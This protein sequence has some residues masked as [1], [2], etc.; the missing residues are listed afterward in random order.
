MSIPF[1]LSLSKYVN[2]AGTDVGFASLLAV[3]MLALLY[4]AGAR[5]TRTLRDQ[6]EEAHNR[7]TSLEARVAQ[8]LRGQAARAPQPTQTGQIPSVAGRPG[9]V[10]PPSVAQP[11]GTGVARIRRP[12]TGGAATVTAPVTA[13]AAA[14][15]GA[16]AGAG[17]P[18]LGSATK[19][20]PSPP[21]PIV[22]A[23]L[24]TSPMTAAAQSV[25]EAY[26]EYD[27]DEEFVEEYGPEDTLFVP[28]GSGTDAVANG[29]GFGAGAAVAAPPRIQFGDDD[30]GG[31]PPRRTISTVEGDSSRP[32]RVA[33]RLVG[34][35]A[36]VVLVA[37]VVVAL[38]VIT[39]GSSHTPKRSAQV[40]TTTTTRRPTT[41]PFNP[42]S[43]KVSVL[44][45]TGLTGVAGAIGTDLTTAGYTVPAPSVT[46]AAVET[47]T[48]TVVGY[49]SG[50]K[51]AALKVAQ[52]LTNKTGVPVTSV[53]PATQAAITSCATPDTGTGTGKCPASVI[54]TVGTDL[55]SAANGG[56][57]A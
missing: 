34:A 7:I 30:A 32:R 47:V 43:I 10:P 26:P 42:K 3:A 36:A 29:A 13:G 8:A 53:A 15:L 51:T 41:V 48:T 35:I 25:P 11:V 54:V 24:S 52:A 44:N 22:A 49:R 12:T 2:S 4:F 39:G 9:V 45:G 57:G 40:R 38:L 37:I 56:S 20:I 46:N 23:P 5:E 16:P 50:Y 6:L 27:P 17:A 19:L 1:A 18:S 28:A 21:A 14:L 31:A 55:A 33:G